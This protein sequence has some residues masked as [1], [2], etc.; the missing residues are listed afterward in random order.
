MLF[1]QYK[2]NYDQLN[3]NY[4][5]S[6]ESEKLQ[7]PLAER[8]MNLDLGPKMALDD[9]ALL[10]TPNPMYG[11]SAFRTAGFKLGGNRSDS[12]GPVI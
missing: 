6:Y 1:F 3:T 4:L 7:V 11:V 5:N 2:I 12:C 8:F 9:S 10:T